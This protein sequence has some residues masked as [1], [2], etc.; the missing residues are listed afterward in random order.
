MENVIQKGIDIKKQIQMVGEGFI[1]HTGDIIPFPLERIFRVYPKLETMGY[2]KI[3]FDIELSEKEYAKGV[4]KHF[5]KAIGS[6][7]PNLE[8][9]Y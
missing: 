4:L 2:M 8:V 3:P 9:Y 5:K 6:E 1:I 7:Y